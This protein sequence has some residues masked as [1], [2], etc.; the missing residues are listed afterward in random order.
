M[1]FSKLPKDIQEGIKG[2]TKDKIFQDRFGHDPQL[3]ELDDEKF[4]AAESLRDLL[5]TL[6]FKFK[7]KGKSF[8][9]LTP[10]TWC[11]L[12]CIESPFVKETSKQATVA[13]LNL[14]FYTLENGVHDDGIVENAAKAIGWC[15]NHNLT[16]EEAVDAINKLI[17]A[18]FAPLKMFPATNTKTIGK[19]MSLFDADW[20]TGL[21]SKVH[22]VTGYSPDYIMNE[23]SMTAACY[24]YIQYCRMQG[25]QQIERRPDEEI[26]R[27]QDVRACEL[28]AERLVE[29]NVIKEED[30][31]DLIKKMS[32]PP[33][34]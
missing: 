14:F 2:L 28:I 21:V 7:Y 9:N 5:T 22:S 11:Y 8:N 27:L 30:K 33:D 32:T 24:Y 26:L 18:S 3:D 12:W 10:L 29:L 13:D 19:Q 31:A 20:I 15:K 25:V 1:F 23:M 6:N 4:N 16:E 34:K 17:I